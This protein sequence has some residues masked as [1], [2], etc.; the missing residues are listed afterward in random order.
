MAQDFADVEAITESD[1]LVTYTCDLRPSVE[2]QQAIR[3]WVEHGGRWLALHGTNCAL[4]P[5]SGD[6]GGLYSA[7]AGLPGVGRHAREP[8][9]LA[10]ADRAVRRAPIIRGP[11]TIPLVAGIEPF[12]TGA[13]RSST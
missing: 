4:D 13:T 11:A 2:Q 5:P 9:H 7:P 10:P 12:E 3:A 6:E 8:V 1:F